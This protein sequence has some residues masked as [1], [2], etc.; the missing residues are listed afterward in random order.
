MLNGKNDNN[1]HQIPTLSSGDTMCICKRRAEVDH[2]FWSFSIPN[3]S[4]WRGIESTPGCVSYYSSETSDDDTVLE[5]SGFFEIPQDF[6]NTSIVGWFNFRIRIF[7]RCWRVRQESGKI[8]NF[9]SIPLAYVIRFRHFLF[10]WKRP[11]WFA[12]YH[13]GC[14]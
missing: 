5:R 14:G 12:A 2:R 10:A 6:F 9:E 1:Q 8:C 3:S 4:T 11:Y 7:F 13:V